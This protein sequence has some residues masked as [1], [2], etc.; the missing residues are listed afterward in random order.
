MR[1]GVAPLPAPTPSPLVAPAD[2]PAP[3]PTLLPRKD[4]PAGAAAEFTT[5]FRK[6]IA[7][8][9]EILAGG[10]PKDGI[11]ALDH[12]HFVGVRDTD[13]WLA[14]HEPVITLQIGD[15]ARAYPVQILVWHE[16]VNDAAYLMGT[17]GTVAFRALWSNDERVL[18]YGRRLPASCSTHSGRGAW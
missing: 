3:T 7:P 14:P 18:R 9:R 6:H 13:R 10:P 1:P 5:D 8:Y 15:D 2:A 16:I 17:N 11:P 4:P 12:P